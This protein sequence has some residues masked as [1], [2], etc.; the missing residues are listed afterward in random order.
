M[1]FVNMQWNDISN[2]TFKTCQ[3]Y[4]PR[5]MQ[6]VIHKLKIFEYEKLINSSIKIDITISGKKKIEEVYDII[7]KTADL[8][9]T[10]LFQIQMINISY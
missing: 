6:L 10:K 8:L 1:E 5:W 2:N 4:P 7:F 9:S 3:Q